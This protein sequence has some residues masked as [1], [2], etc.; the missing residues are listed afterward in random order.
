ME[1]QTIGLDIGYGFT[2]ATD[3]TDTVVFPSVGGDATQADFDNEI[4]RS[5]AGFKITLRGRDYFYGEHA[6]KH[7]RN[8][9]AL[10]ARERTEQVDLM[11]LLFCGAMAEL[12]VEGRIHLCTGLPIDWFADEAALRDLLAGEHVFS[13]NGDLR[14]VSVDEVVVVP[15]PFGSFFDT[16]LDDFGIFTSSQFRGKVGILDIGT[17]TTDYA[18]SDGLEYVAK[19]SGSKT[20]AMSTVWRQVR[21][22]IKVNHGLDYELHE[23]DAFMRDG[24]KVIVQG[25]SHSIEPLIGPAV[26]YLARQVLAGAREFWG[27]ARDYNLILLTGGGAEY[28][29]ER[30]QAVYPHAR[31]VRAPHLANVQGFRKFAFRKFGG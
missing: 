5:G 12:D 27:K 1:K 23:I 25:K 13:V 9:M 15:Q 8:S 20:A 29:K 7:S 21:D 26:D 30:V 4:I 10:F 6:Q 2:K 17:F 11:R 24:R 19:S 31:V 28:V 22:G 3:G 18:L 14:I 16:I